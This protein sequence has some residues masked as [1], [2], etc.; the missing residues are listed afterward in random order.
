MNRHSI[1]GAIGALAFLICPAWAGST[2][3]ESHPR[4]QVRDRWPAENLSGKIDMVEPGKNKLFV[5]ALNGTTFDFVV[6][7]A[8]KIEDGSQRLT[9]AQ[10]AAKNKG[11]VTVHYVP[12]RKGDVASSIEV[13]H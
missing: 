5:D 7:R 12:E 3:T 11:Q 8:T 6:T 4:A 9:L 1:C 10:L 13:Q 2:H